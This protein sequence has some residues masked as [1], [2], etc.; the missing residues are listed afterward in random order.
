MSGLCRGRRWYGRRKQINFARL[1]WSW[2]CIK[3]MC[4]YAGKVLVQSGYQKEVKGFL[5]SF[6]RNGRETAIIS[7]GSSWSRYTG[8]SMVLASAR[9]WSYRWEHPAIALGA[10]I[11]RSWDAIRKGV[12]PSVGHGWD[13]T[14]HVII[15]HCKFE[16]ESPNRDR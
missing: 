7:C 4:Q 11:E 2:S 8:S 15:E 1:R 14:M 9:P 3:E 5:K 12:F 10:R 6:R 13:Q 16:Y